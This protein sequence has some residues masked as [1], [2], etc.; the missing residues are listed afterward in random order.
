MKENH[1]VK[2]SIEWTEE[3]A[4]QLS[5]N[6]KEWVQ[7]EDSYEFEVFCEGLGFPSF[8]LDELAEKYDWFKED[9]EM[10]KVDIA[11]RMVINVNNGSYPGDA[12]EK[13]IEK[14]DMTLRYF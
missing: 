14:Y 9:V 13:N 1:R 4:Q 11:C 2:N 7:K 3:K 12:F 10:A 5:D 6:L 8:T